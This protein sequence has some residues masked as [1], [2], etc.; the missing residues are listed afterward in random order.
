MKSLLLDE[1][2]DL[3]FQNGDFVWVEGDE[4]LAQQVHITLKTVKEE[5]FLDMDEGLDREPIFAKILKENE[6][7]DS[8]IEAIGQVQ[9]ISGVE[10]ITFTRSGRVLSIDLAIRKED[11]EVVQLQEVEV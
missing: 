2:G 5:W 10:N 1:N 3:V 7:R 9:G 6:A 8:I 11:G 4:E